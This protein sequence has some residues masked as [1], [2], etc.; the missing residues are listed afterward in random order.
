MNKLTVC[1]IK[2]IV[3]LAVIVAPFGIFGT[4]VVDLRV[5]ILLDGFG[6]VFLVDYVA[7]VGAIL[8]C[9]LDLKLLCQLCQIPKNASSLSEMSSMSI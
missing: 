1:A 4:L 5:K 6:D 7:A 9:I 3:P 8:G 2:V